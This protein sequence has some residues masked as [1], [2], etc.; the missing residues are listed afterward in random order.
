MN[1]IALLRSLIKL[2]FLSLIA[3]RLRS[4]A[5]FVAQFQKWEAAGLR[6]PRK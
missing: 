6:T 1:S 4:T 5:C 2:L 3:A